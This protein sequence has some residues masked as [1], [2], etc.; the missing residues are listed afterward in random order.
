MVFS[1]FAVI[2]LVAGCDAGK[3]KAPITDADIR[4][5]AEGLKTEFVKNAPPENVFAENENADDHAII[6]LN[7][8][9]ISSSIINSQSEQENELII[10]EF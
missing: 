1:I 6:I 8:N 2:L 3:S 5:G 10:N 9:Q 4:T 7:N